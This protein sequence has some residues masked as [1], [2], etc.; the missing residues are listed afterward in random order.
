MKFRGL[1][2]QG[3]WTF[4][5][6][7]QDYLTD[8]DAIAAD[9]KTALQIFQG[10]VFWAVDAGVDWWNLLGSRDQVG[11]LLQ[12]RQIIASRDGITRIKNVTAALNAQRR[13]SLTYSVDTV[14]SRNISGTVEVP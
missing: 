8:Q 5:N 12:T 11:V 1:D 13:L 3:D 14:F 7:Q 9:V 4:G 6:G 10:E 2:A